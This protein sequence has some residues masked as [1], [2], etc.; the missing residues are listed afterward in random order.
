MTE[1]N[2]LIVGL[3]TIGSFEFSV[4]GSC[5]TQAGAS[6]FP[7]LNTFHT[8]QN[9]KLDVRASVHRSI[10]VNYDQQ[11]ATILIQLFIPNQLY[12]FRAMFS[13][14]VRSTWLYLQLLILFTDTAAGLCHW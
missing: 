2:G 3:L 6:S 14:T 10:I 4:G 13:P 12:M 1:E 11:D 8:I 9:H 5:G 7:R